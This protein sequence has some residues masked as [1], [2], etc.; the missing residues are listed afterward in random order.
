ME[1]GLG[2]FGNNSASSE[3]SSVLERLGQRTDQSSHSLLSGDKP[4]MF[5]HYTIAEDRCGTQDDVMSGILSRLARRQR[6]PTYNTEPGPLES[7]QEGHCG[8][9]FSL[10]DKVSSQGHLGGAELTHA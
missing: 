8:H 10:D 5:V 1:R 9:R 7:G 6:T 4:A 3:N 2:H